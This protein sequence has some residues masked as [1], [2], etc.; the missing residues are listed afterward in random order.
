MLHGVFARLYQHSSTEQAGSLLQKPDWM[1]W[2]RPFAVISTQ[3][4]SAN[5]GNSGQ[6]VNQKGL[7]NAGAFQSR[8][9]TAAN[10]NPLLSVR[11]CMHL[12]ADIDVRSHVLP[13]PI[14]LSRMYSHASSKARSGQSSCVGS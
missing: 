2:V 1:G 11:R 12:R 14:I 8:H 7:A 5:G 6:K 9:H 3:E 13:H 10:L 4:G